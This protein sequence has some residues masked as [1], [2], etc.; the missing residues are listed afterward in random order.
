MTQGSW[1]VVLV[2]SSSAACAS[3]PSATHATL[4][5]APQASAKASPA[6]SAPNDGNEWRL[7]W[8]PDPESGQLRVH[9]ETPDVEVTRWRLPPGELSELAVT[10]AK[11]E[12]EALAEGR[13]LRLVIERALTAPLTIRYTVTPAWT[14]GCPF[15]VTPNR[16]VFCGGAALAVPEGDDGRDRSLAIRMVSDEDLYRA[17]ASSFGL[18][19]DAHV[20]ASF[21]EVA[22][23]GFLFGDIH[24]AR[25]DAPEGRDHAA[26]LGYFAFD[27]RWVAAEAAGIRTAVD[28]WLRIRR[29]DDDPTV[30]LLF[31]GV[32]DTTQRVR[33]RPLHRGAL[34]E[35][36]PSAVWSPRARLDLARHL[37]QR[38]IGGAV[39]IVA[40][41]ADWWFDE[42]VAHGIALRV[43][44]DV[45][46][47]TR[48]EAAAEV[49]SWLAHEALSDPAR[50]SLATLTRAVGDADEGVRAD[51][52]AL[53]ASRGALFALASSGEGL[54]R[55]ARQL[56]TLRAA[57]A[58][59]GVEADTLFAAVG[60]ELGAARAQGLRAALEDGTPIPLRASDVDPCLS[61]VTRR[62]AAFDLGFTPSLATDRVVAV[63]P[64]GPAARAGVREGDT[65][66]SLDHV[67][68]NAQQP[69]ALTLERG[70]TTVRLSYLPRGPAHAARALTT[71][72]RRACTLDG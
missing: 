43:L 25:F 15:E 62:V 22:R 65:I 38:T 70:E 54:Q 51:A 23:A 21:A 44:L 16:A 7:T 58:G 53:L 10:D 40:P 17:A 49:S 33:I 12:L 47:V 18:G 1:L 6:A 4:P 20:T 14:S 48:E 39:S 11:G 67:D 28:R 32:A 24:H 27:P 45:G 52:R 35:A 61:M 37:V 72:S 41:G 31:A 57:Q 26:W 3:T 69:V 50:A 71:A 9:I 2:L 60:Q 8:R 5:A 59:R 42:G 19:R 68:G 13:G 66:A 56:L 55:A 30:G 29:P 63:D 34:I 46:V 36:G 64:T